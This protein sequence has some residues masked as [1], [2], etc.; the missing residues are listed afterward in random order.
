MVDVPG[1]VQELYVA[2]FGRP[3]DYLGLQYWSNVFATPGGYDQIVTAFSGSDEYKAK[4]GGMDNR[5]LVDTVYEN[6]F[7]RHAESAGIDFW[8]GLLDNKAVT[9]GD[10][11]TAVAGG[12]QGTDSVIFDAKVQVAELFTSHLDQIPERVAYSGSSAN[13]LVA[14]YLAAITDPA[15][16]GIAADPANVDA[17]ISKLTEGLQLPGVSGVAAH[18]VGVPDAALPP[19]YG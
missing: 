4:Y 19:A 5:V 12:A 11:V 14:A 1:Q 15:S 13:A 6:L 10:V 9:I 18:L 3:A 17:L 7:G 8:A 16:A 2:Y